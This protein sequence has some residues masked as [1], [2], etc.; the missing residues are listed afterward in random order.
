MT[1]QD[2]SPQML[3]SKPA[4]DEVCPP[5]HDRHQPKSS[6]P[7]KPRRDHMVK[8]ATPDICTITKHS[9]IN[10]HISCIHC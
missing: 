3:Q 9:E 1:Q 6:S 5:C 2:C 7:T 4:N 10:K 8:P